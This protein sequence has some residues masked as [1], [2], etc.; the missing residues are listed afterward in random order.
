VPNVEP[1][2]P[3]VNSSF[4]FAAS[5]NISTIDLVID[6]TD[7]LVALEDI[8]LVVYRIFL[9]DGVEGIGLG[10]P[11]ST[12]VEALDNDGQY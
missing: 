11:N 9:P 2:L 3:A 7:D 10:G 6:V 5:T 1:S 8:E 12:L 4:S